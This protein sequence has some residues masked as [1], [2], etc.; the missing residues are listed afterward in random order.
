MESRPHSLLA[1]STRGM[2]LVFFLFICPPLKKFLTPSW[3]V[4]EDVPSISGAY[5]INIG[6]MME[7]WTNCLFRSTMHR[8]I[9]TGEERYSVAFFL[10][11]SKECLVECLKNCCSESSPPK[12]PP[13]KA[14]DY[15]DGRYRAIALHAPESYAP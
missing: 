2:L 6:H 1:S 7:R 15:L 11:P 9:I 12:F 5:I 4:W 13:I 14:F 3:Q 10:N 8:V